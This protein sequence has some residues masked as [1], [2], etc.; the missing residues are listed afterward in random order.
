MIVHEESNPD[1]VDVTSDLTKVVRKVREAVLKGDFGLK[2][3]SED[4][5]NLTRQFIKLKTQ[6]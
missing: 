4:E 3:C 6:L 5:L 1:P 2:S